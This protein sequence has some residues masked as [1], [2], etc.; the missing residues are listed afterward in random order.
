MLHW[1]GAHPLLLTASQ[2]D[3]TH[4]LLH[5][6]TPSPLTLSPTA[7]PMM[8]DALS[9]PSSPPP[10]LLGEAPLLDCSHEGR[11]AIASLKNQI[12]FPQG[13]Q[14]IQ[15]RL[16]SGGKSV[17]NAQRIIKYFFNKKINKNFMQH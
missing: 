8:P 11:K 5:P 1:R 2:Q 10:S 7:P 9:V 16:N 14:D 17:K 6:L 3:H 15:H 13:G 12:Q 4:L